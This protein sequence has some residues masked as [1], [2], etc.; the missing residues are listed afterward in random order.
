MNFSSKPDAATTTSSD[1]GADWSQS[2]LG[3]TAPI[4]GARATGKVLIGTSSWNDHAPF[5]P[6]GTKPNER[7]SYY[8]SQF[9]IVEVNTSYY[10]IPSRKTVEQWVERTPDHFI[11]DVKPPRELT[12][13]PV[14][15]RG[16]APE[17][18][19]DTAAAFAEAISPL[20][21]AGKL[22]AVTFQFPPSYRNTEE[23]QEYLKL[24]PELLPGV[25]I[26][27]E[28]RRRDWLDEEHADETLDLL[29]E[30]GLSYTM[31]DEPQVGSGSVPPVYAVT[32]PRLSIIRFHG[33]NAENWYD[34]TG[35]GGS[36]FDWDYSDRELREWIP[37]IDRAEHEAEA[38]HIFFNTNVD[39]QGPRNAHR[40]MEQLGIEWA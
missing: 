16:E 24:L 5:Y 18:D 20:V 22:G 33:R 17:P 28:F 35:S 14:S 12:S 9:P 1:D 7:L 11:F 19:A 23:H 39:D 34:F 15:P 36:R 31:A 29:R 2:D 37:K 3:L 26:S 4:E 8:A 21:A 10:A 40:L 25:P 6:P 27:V 30:A 32:N 38:V 13:T